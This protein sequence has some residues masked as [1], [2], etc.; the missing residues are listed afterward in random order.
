MHIGRF[1]LRAVVRHYT[2][3]KKPV[4]GKL[5]KKPEEP[6]DYCCGN[7]C[8]HCVWFDYFDAMEQWKAQQNEDVEPEDPGMDAFAKLERKLA[9]ETK[10]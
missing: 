2:K 4:V 3:I 7:G 9:S 10:D 1:G 8:Q 6:G 5:L